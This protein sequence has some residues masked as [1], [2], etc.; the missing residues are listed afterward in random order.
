M[1]SSKSSK[2]C[3]NGRV[4]S[5]TSYWKSKRPKNEITNPQS[6][7]YRIQELRKLHGIQDPNLG[8]VKCWAGRS[9]PP[10]YAGNPLHGE[11]K[12]LI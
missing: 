3:E 1:S 9:P 4:K 6:Q 12:N 8:I 5:Q 10:Y 11:M 2:N 7:I